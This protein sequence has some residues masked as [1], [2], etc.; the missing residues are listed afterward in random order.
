[1][2]LIP[3][4]FAGAS[5]GARQRA[6]RSRRCPASSSAA[7]TERS[8]SAWPRFAGSRTALATWRGFGA[9]L[10]ALKKGCSGPSEAARASQTARPWPR[11]APSCVS[12]PASLGLSR[13]RR[14]DD[15]TRDAVA[16]RRR[17]VGR[18]LR[19]AFSR[20]PL[21]SGRQ[22]HATRFKGMAVSAHTMSSDC[23][24]QCSALGNAKLIYTPFGRARRRL[25]RRPKRPAT[26]RN[27]PC[28]F[29]WSLKSC[30]LHLSEGVA[31][32]NHSSLMLIAL[33]IL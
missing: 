4:P 16:G 6:C 17:T 11:A 26:S 32:R 20:F 13:W 33:G 31:E 3:H 2:M 19:G 21:T 9:A 12:W 29:K 5:L 27:A 7:C 22:K 30:E 1:M 18:A 23:S 14:L 24:R 15:A 10:A 8:L 25:E 28:T